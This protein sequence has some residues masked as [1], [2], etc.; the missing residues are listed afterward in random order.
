MQNSSKSGEDPGLD[1]RVP[2]RHQP[3]DVVQAAATSVPPS[4]GSMDARQ[5]EVGA[6]LQL[7]VKRASALT[8]VKWNVEQEF[9]KNSLLNTFDLRLRNSFPTT[10]SDDQVSS[11]GVTN[12]QL[13]TD[14]PASLNISNSCRATGINDTS[15]TRS[16]PLDVTKI[17]L[18]DAWKTS[19]SAIEAK[20]TSFDSRR[21]PESSNEFRNKSHSYTTD[22]FI[23]S[24]GLVNLYPEMSK[25]SEG[26]VGIFFPNVL[27]TA[28]TCTGKKP[29]MADN[30]NT[31]ANSEPSFVAPPSDAALKI[32]NF[33]HRPGWEARD[34]ILAKESG[35]AE[36]DADDKRCRISAGTGGVPPDS[37]TITPPFSTA[38]GPP[39]TTPPP[40]GRPEFLLLSGRHEPFPSGGGAGRRFNVGR[41]IGWPACNATSLEGNTSNTRFGCGATEPER[42]RM[43]VCFDPENEIPLLQKWFQE[44]QHP[45]RAQ[46]IVPR[47]LRWK[48]II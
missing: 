44:N 32:T 10:T 16:S 43:R 34:D 27:K 23:S 38:T 6:E 40:L 39:E 2:R 30:L 47:L 14:M 28:E 15:K 29:A 35:Q 21:A 12:S 36:I 8:D 31:Q 41:G 5:E 4:A 25:P 9:L 20:N 1:L 13:V 24:S 18:A 48:D 33:P 26:P 7:P 46:V 19:V 42:P 22:D 3:V 37:C 17:S 45:T 11:P